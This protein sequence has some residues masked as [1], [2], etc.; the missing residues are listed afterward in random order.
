MVRLGT[1]E[2]RPGWCGGPRQGGRPVLAHQACIDAEE[3]RAAAAQADADHRARLSRRAAGLARLGITG[4][5][6]LGLALLDP[7]TDAAALEAELAAL[8]G[9]AGETLTPGC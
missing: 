6:E 3:V 9:I 8:E 4:A 2:S 7:D 1:T 5:L